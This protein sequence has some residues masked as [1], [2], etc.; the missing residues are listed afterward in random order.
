VA[1]VTDEVSVAPPQGRTGKTRTRKPPSLVGW[2]LL[3][4]VVFF[5]AWALASEYLVSGIRLPS[6]TD[7]AG[8][9]REIILH[10]DFLVHFWATMKRTLICLP[11][12]FVIGAAIGIAMGSSLWWESFFRDIVTVLL[13][14]PGLIVVLLFILIMGLDPKGPIIAI[15]VTN[16][17]F[18]TVQ[19]WEGVKSLPTELSQMGAAYGV[20]PLKRIRHIILPALAPFLFTAFTYAFT[21]TWKLAMVSELFGGQA[22]VGFRMRAEFWQFNVSGMLAW[23][24]MLFFITLAIERLLLKRLE[25]HVLRWREASF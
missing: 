19:V 8:D 17:G 4:Y 12:V 25:A 2:R 18:V 13:S 11:M 6:P 3:G 23:A 10:G 24:L 20:A 21:L 9:M 16:F 7:I 22:G 1:S 15:V 5:A 14:L